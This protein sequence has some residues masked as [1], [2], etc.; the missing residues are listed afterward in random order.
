MQWAAIAQQ[1]AG[2]DFQRRGD[3]HPDRRRTSGRRAARPDNRAA[4]FGRPRGRASRRE[5]PPPGHRTSKAMHGRQSTLPSRSGLA[6]S[7]WV[8]VTQGD[9]LLVPGGHRFQ[10]A[11][12]A[13]VWNQRLNLV[14]TPRL[15]INGIP[16]A[17]GDSS[18]T[19]AVAGPARPGFAH[20]V[21]MQVVRLP[22]P[23]ANR[24]RDRERRTLLGGAQHRLQTQA[25]RQPAL[26]AR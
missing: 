4:P 19:V 1:Q 3:A 13:G 16:D 11:H 7:R 14:R 15:S 17:S 25:A 23:V 8:W 9:G 5:S 12:G 18:Q 21:P 10:Q 22:R 24:S 20:C 2:G 26:R 6:G